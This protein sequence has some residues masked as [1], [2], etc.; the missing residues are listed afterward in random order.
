LR[1]L[2]DAFA[3]TPW[4][5][6]EI[7]ARA[8]AMIAEPEGVTPAVLVADVEASVPGSASYLS[9]GVVDPEQLGGVSATISTFLRRLREIDLEKRIRYTN[10]TL[11]KAAL[12]GD[13]AYDELF[14]SVAELQRELS[15]LRNPS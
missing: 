10:A 2:G 12:T 4:T 8:Q 6:E 3:R 15:E 14:K 7:S 1:R 13:A 9:A 11:K 5:S